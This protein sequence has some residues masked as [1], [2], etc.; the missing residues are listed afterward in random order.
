MYQNT[1]ALAGLDSRAVE[2]VTSREKTISLEILVK[3][4]RSFLGIGGAAAADEM[5]AGKRT[6]RHLAG[7]SAREEVSKKWKEEGENACWR[8]L[9]D[10]RSV[11]ESSASNLKKGLRVTRRK[12][13]ETEVSW[14][15]SL[16]AD[17]ILE[18]RKR[19]DPQ[20]ERYR[21]QK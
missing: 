3:L 14:T 8:R 11:I 19:M 7:P 2:W 16:S 17:Q 15:S 13:R 10:V 20:I 18:V 9:S 21:R 4:Y 12:V 5:I 6:L 1:A